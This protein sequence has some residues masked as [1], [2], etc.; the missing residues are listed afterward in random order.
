MKSGYMYIAAAIAFVLLFYGLCTT[1]VNQGWTTV[2][3]SFGKPVKVISA[4]GL[5][6]K[7]PY[8]FQN[9][10]KIDVRLI[11]LQPKPS[12][13][14]TADKKNLILESSICYK[15]ND[16]VLFM[17]TVRN[18]EGLEM[19]LTD[20]LSSHTGQLL[21]VMELSDLVNVD[22]SKIKFRDMNRDLSS[23][24]GRDG[25]NLGIQVEQVFIK[26]LMLP[27]SNTLAVYNRMRAE[28]DRIA[29]KYIAEGEEK[30]LE[31]RAEADKTSRIILS[32]AESQAFIIKGQADADAMNTYGKA[33]QKNLTVY[34]FL[35]SLEA[36]EKMFGEQTVIILDEESPILETLFS[37]ENSVR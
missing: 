7:L 13:F 5:Y 15:I 22:T 10:K 19:R 27:L 29:K 36:Y 17:R 20:L 4:P 23:L 6:L 34:K 18:R 11:I 3:M 16:P 28:R 26:R 32:E 30:A 9:A 14:L 24:M 8:P 25:T 1:V 12:E 35:R 31:I 21:G 33:Y 2:L 37:G